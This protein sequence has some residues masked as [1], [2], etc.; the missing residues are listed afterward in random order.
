MNYEEN[1]YVYEIGRAISKPPI[2]LSADV[3]SFI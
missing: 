1:Y 2:T 3:K